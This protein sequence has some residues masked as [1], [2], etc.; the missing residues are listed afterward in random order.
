MRHCLAMAIEI[1]P[2]KFEGD[3]VDGHRATVTANLRAALAALA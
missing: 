2:R 3:W 1:T